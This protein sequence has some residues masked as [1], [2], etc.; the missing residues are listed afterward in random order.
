MVIQGHPRSKVKLEFFD[1]ISTYN[2]YKTSWCTKLV[3]AKVKVTQGL[4]NH[5]STYNG[6]MTS[7]CTKLVKVTHWT[8]WIVLV[9]I[10]ITSSDFGRPRGV[11]CYRHDLVYYQGEGIFYLKKK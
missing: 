8:D 5:I 6:Y 4:L 10:L 3:N 11:T 9:G 7:W 2:G 1:H